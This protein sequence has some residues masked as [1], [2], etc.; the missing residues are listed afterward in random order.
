MNIQRMNNME[1]I[2]N[3][4][5][6]LA[7]LGFLFENPK[8]GYELYKEVS[9]PIGIGQVYRI[10]IGKMYSILKKLENQKLISATI[11]QEG[12]RPPKNLYQLTK[13]GKS[14]FNDWMSTPIDHGRDF[15]ILFLLKLFFINRSKTYDAK[16]LIS[17]QNRECRKWEKKIFLSMGEQNSENSYQ[18]IVAQYRLSQIEGYSRWL[19]WCER[20]INEKSNS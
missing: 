10:K 9:D 4:K 12:N 6:E 13:S 17:K 5:I 18:Q 11:L 2:N 8:H 7:L 20:K 3:E 1:N 15:R 14:T 19:D 16:D